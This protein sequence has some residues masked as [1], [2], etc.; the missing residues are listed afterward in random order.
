MK[1][2][3]GFVSNSSTSSFLIYG[4]ILDRD[5]I[6]EKRGLSDEEFEDKYCGR[7]YDLVEEEMKDIDGFE[8]H[9]PEYYDTFYI[10]VS[11]DSVKDDETGFQFKARVRRVLEEKFGDNLEFGTYAEAWRDG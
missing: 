4:T 3:N 6:K 10:G 11:W 5:S 7:I 9:E 1:I 2:R 8:W